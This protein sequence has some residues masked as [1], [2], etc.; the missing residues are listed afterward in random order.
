MN[1][2]K[3]INVLRAIAVSAVLFY[4]FNPHV[5]KYGYL[6]VDIFFVISGFL[7]TLYIYKENLN[8]KFLFSTFYKRR[9]IRILPI[10]LVVVFFSL[11]ASKFVLLD[12]DF[13]RFLESFIASLG[14]LANIFFWKTGGY[15][16]ESDSL[17]PLLHI[18]SLSVEGQYYLFFPIFFFFI[19][20]F[21]KSFRF[22]IIVFFFIFIKSFF[23]SF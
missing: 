21:I 19:L 22:I 2:R 15:F 16:G 18:W 7:I 3:E 23:S 8:S 11:I 9:I 12:T 10:T 4:H 1:Y 17:K 13:N 20:K 5:F 14:F 6:G